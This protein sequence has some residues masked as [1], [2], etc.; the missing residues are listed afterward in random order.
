MRA[1]ARAIGS[2][3][4]TIL[5]PGGIALAATS[6]VSAPTSP[7]PTVAPA[8]SATPGATL[9]DP[10]NLSIARQ[11]AAIA[12]TPEKTNA[13]VVQMEQFIFQTRLTS[14]FHGAHVNDP[15]LAAILDA[16]FA[17]ARPL[18]HAALISKLPA[19][20]EATARAYAQIFSRTELS[21]LLD[22]ARTPAGAKF[23]ARAIVVGNDQ[24]IVK[25]TL[26]IEAA[27]LESQ[28]QPEIDLL[29]KVG[30]YLATH[31]EVAS[32]IRAAE[33]QHRGADPDTTAD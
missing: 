23:L 15:A 14:W 26:D 32:K 3:W 33:A 13:F 9:V 4:C 28:K 20:N 11:I 27:G 2:V 16:Y 10:D 31:P 25:C 30:A 7:V 19:L 1:I 6:P 12:L 18:V 5:I 8:G 22:F 17:S 29:A 24:E 21:T